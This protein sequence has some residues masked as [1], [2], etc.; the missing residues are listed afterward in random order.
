MEAC[1]SSAKLYRNR[2]RPRNGITVCDTTNQ[3][4]MYR[5]LTE[6]ESHSSKECLE[7]EGSL[8]ID[9]ESFERDLYGAD[10]FLSDIEAIP[11]LKL[12]PHLFQ[13]V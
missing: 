8:I 2:F 3:V 13:S 4:H 7:Y 12:Y 5:Q 6:L 10:T 9:D 11:H 1:V